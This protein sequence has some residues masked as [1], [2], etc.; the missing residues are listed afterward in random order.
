LTAITHDTYT[1]FAMK[2]TLRVTNFCS[3]KVWD[4]FNVE[5][6][7]MLWDRLDGH[8]VSG[9]VDAVGYVS[10]LLFQDDGSLLFTIRCNTLET[11]YIIPKWS[12]TL[13]GVS[14]T[15][16]HVT[17]DTCTVSLIPLTQEWTNLWSS[18]LWDSINIEYDMVAKY[19]S[20]MVK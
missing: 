15:V 16:V 6:S 10:H 1:F 9:H 12:I 7:L 13:N 11:R 8:I 20:N 18:K 17:I 4:S 2:E 3:K 5:R 19:I 14:L